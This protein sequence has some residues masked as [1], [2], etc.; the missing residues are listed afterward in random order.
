M[1]SVRQRDTG[2]EMRLRKALHRLGMR[3]R[4]HDRKLPGSPDLV[5]QRF[6]AVVFVH[7][8]F[9][10]S[11][12]CK[13]SSTPSN[14]REF[15]MEKFSTNKA[16]DERNLKALLAGGWRVLTVWECALKARHVSSDEIVASRVAAWL[17][18]N[19]RTGVIGEREIRA[20]NGSSNQSGALTQNA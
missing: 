13:Y 9:W 7:G 19:G 5:F 3:Y 15:W 12:G 4:L 2:P 11:H 1:A 18:G 20:K 16:R 8:C 10:H 14:R 17:R 6:K